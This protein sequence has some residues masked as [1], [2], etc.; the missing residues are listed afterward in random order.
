MKHK[1]AMFPVR[2]ERRLHTIE[3]V[4][5]ID[6]GLGG[7]GWA[8]FESIK[9]KTIKAVKPTDSG[10]FTPKRSALWE[11]KVSSACSW[12]D[13]F[14]S[15]V[16]PSVVVLEFPELW[17]TSAISIASAEKGDLFKLTYLIGGL[18]EVARRAG[19]LSPVLITPKGWKGQLPKDAVIRRIK[20]RLPGLPK[21]RNHEG[22]AIGMGLA[23]QGVL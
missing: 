16:E 23:A 1:Q 10:V 14:C 18:G 13:G 20:R 15:S 21:I 22:D 19:G 6:P 12:F 5:F 4:V 7:T 17:T 2:A 11:S 3:R 9:T 8:F